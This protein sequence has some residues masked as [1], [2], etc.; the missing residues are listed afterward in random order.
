MEIAEVGRRANMQ[1]PWERDG[2]RWHTVDRVGRD[3]QPAQWDGAALDLIERRIHQLG[4]FSPTD[5]KS[6]SV[7]EIAARRK[8]DGWFLHAI[9]GESR[10]FDV[11]ENTLY[12]HYL[13]AIAL[14]GLGTFYYN[15]LR[16]V[17]DQSKRTDHGHRPATARCMLP[18]INRT[19]CCP[20]NMWRFFGALPEYL[21]SYDKEGLF[22]NLYTS[23]A[24]N[25]TLADGRQIALT[26][27]TEYP[28]QGRRLKGGITRSVY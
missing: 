20:S 24:V 11:I 10:Y 22:V 23:S 27:E 19:A 7:V 15:P 26:V 4:E 18:E 14:N 3:G 9:T 25:H 13:G 6:R 5:W 21:F 28:H 1:M 2:R 16:V 17:G 12:N 8:R